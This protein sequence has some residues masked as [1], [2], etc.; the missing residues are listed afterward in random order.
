MKICLPAKAK[1]KSTCSGL[2]F[3]E[4]CTNLEKVTEMPMSRILILEISKLIYL[5]S[6]NVVLTFLFK[7]LLFSNDLQLIFFI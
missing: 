5:L 3:A 1:I 2:D 4:Q 7:L 6:F